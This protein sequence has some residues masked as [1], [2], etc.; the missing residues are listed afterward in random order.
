VTV[1]LR[2]VCDDDGPLLLEWYASTRAAEMAMVPW[3]DD[4][5]RAF[6]EMQFTAQ[7]DGYAASRPNAVHRIICADQAP[8]GRIYFDRS[9]ARLH[10]LDI[11]IAPERRNQGIGSEVL[12]GMVAEADAHG[13][14]V[15]IYVESYN[16]SLRL[17]ERLGFGVASVDGYL[18]KLERPA[19]RPDDSPRSD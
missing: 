2:E 15:S 19:T 1:S 3:T 14:A 8:V 9:E 7:R 6:V 5:K 13:K 11:T 4:Q 18:L 10:I 17:F 12:A 16:P